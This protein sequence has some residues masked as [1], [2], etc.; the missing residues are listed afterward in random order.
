[1]HIYIYMYICKYIYMHIY[2]ILIYNVHIYT[3]MHVYIHAYIHI[4]YYIYT[5]I[6]GIHH[7]K[8][9]WSTYRKIA[10]VW[11]EPTTTNLNPCS[12]ALTDCA[13]RPGVQL[14]L[15]TNFVQL[16]QFHRC[17]VSNSI[18]AIAFVSRRVLDRNW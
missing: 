8:I 2:N 15:R 16:L 4:I 11:F 12:H 17:S 18:S 1:M 5:Y 14:T 9:L 6:Y 3:Y 13:I 7:W 10:W